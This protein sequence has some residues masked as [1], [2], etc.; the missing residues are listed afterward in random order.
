M[1]AQPSPLW[2]RPVPA[3]V[4]LL[5][6]GAGGGSSVAGMLGAW[7]PPQVAV[8][9]DGPAVAVTS[10]DALVGYRLGQVEEQVRALRDEAARQGQVLTRMCAVTP[11]CSEPTAAAE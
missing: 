1:S 5:V 10:Q 3:W 9:G 8:G 11:G 4:L 7:G 2:Q 6:L